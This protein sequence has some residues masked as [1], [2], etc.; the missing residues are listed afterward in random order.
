MED[1][2]GVVTLEFRVDALQNEFQHTID[3]YKIMCK[4]IQSSSE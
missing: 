2:S 1:N 4:C 3:L